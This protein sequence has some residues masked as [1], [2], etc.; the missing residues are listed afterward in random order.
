MGDAREW[1]T[2]DICKL[3]TNK[4]LTHG[5]FAF[6]ISALSSNEP[7]VTGVTRLVGPVTRL[8]NFK[9]R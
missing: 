3:A 5:I 1:E 6:C 4:K 2:E 7:R 8:H 9:V